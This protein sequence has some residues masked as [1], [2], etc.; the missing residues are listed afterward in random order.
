MVDSS[1]EVDFRW[2]ERV[3]GREVNIQEENATGVWTLALVTRSAS[4]SSAP[5]RFLLM[6]VQVPL[7]LLASE[8][9]S[10]SQPMALN[11]QD[12]GTLL[13]CRS[14]TSMLRT[15]SFSRGPAEQDE[16]GSL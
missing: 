3:V 4:H 5:L 1:R 14:Q 2:F 13:G 10:I 16:G 12:K 8:T 11:P 6:S 15:R 7:W 9:T